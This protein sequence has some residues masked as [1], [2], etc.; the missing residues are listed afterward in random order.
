MANLYGQGGRSNLRIIKETTFGTTPATP[1][2]ISMPV[3]T[4]DLSLTKNRVEG[5]DLTADRMSRIDRHGTKRVGGSI[6]TWLRPADLQLL[7][8][9]A[10]FS[11][12]DVGTTITPGLTPITFSME[13]AALDIDE[14]RLATGVGISS[15]ALNMTVDERVQ[16]TFG[17]VG[18]NIVSAQTSG[19]TAVTADS[20]ANPFDSF[21]GSISIDGTAS[22][23]ITNFT[24]TLENSLAPTFV[25]GDPLATSLEY[26]RAAVSGT[27]TAYYKDQTLIDLFV[28][29][30]E[31]ALVFVLDDQNS[32][33]TYTF[34]LPRCKANAGSPPVTD[35]QSRTFT[36]DY[37]ALY[38]SS[39][40]YNIQLTKSA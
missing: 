27:I 26:G 32:G 18:R 13:D 19:A 37:V 36:L 11:Q 15:M 10:F 7:V 29:E 30:T 22:D 31:F 4:Y 28:D 17:L 23:V 38:D 5:A 34:D 33:L 25:L 24:M 8:E 3:E 21:S 20:G 9:G 16:A 14:Y 12:F 40:T 2:F 35:E 39:D 1:T 6:Q